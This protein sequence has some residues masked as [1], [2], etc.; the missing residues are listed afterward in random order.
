MLNRPFVGPGHMVQITYTG[1]QVAQ[2]DFQNKGRCI[3]LEVPPC[4]LLTSI[5]N[6]YHVTGSCKGPI[7]RKEGSE[8]PISRNDDYITFSF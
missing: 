6:L 8:H 2:W 5:C 7:L 1:E 4:N 3:V